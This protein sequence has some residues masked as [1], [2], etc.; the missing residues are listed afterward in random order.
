VTDWTREERDER[1]VPGGEPG[2]RPEP[3]APDAGTPEL[4]APDRPPAERADERRTDDEA[5]PGQEG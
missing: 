2:V 1:E 5:A 4:D 3:R